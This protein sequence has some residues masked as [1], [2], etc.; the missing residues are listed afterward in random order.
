MKQK[1]KKKIK[2]KTPKEVKTKSNRIYGKD[3]IFSGQSK[4][5]PKLLDIRYEKDFRL[6]KNKIKRTEGIPKIK[7]IEGISKTLRKPEMLD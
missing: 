2:I 5:F 3:W 1:P 6:Q 4:N 7:R